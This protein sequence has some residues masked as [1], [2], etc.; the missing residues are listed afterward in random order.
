MISQVKYEIERTYRQNIG[1]KG[2]RWSV[3][4]FFDTVYSNVILPV[5]NR[6]KAVLSNI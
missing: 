3:C 5:G 4:L 1:K 6:G 2:V